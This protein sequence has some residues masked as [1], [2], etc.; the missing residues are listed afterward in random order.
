MVI[1]ASM[2]LIFHNLFTQ[3]LPLWNHY[4]GGVDCASELDRRGICERPGGLRSADAATQQSSFVTAY[5]VDR[6]RVNAEYEKVLDW[7]KQVKSERGELSYSQK[8]DF[9]HMP[10]VAVIVYKQEHVGAEPTWDIR[11]ALPKVQEI[12]YQG[13]DDAIG[14]YLSR[15]RHVRAFLPRS[16]WSFRLRCHP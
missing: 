5:T 7:C 12:I 10:G 9:L 13:A 1:F 16:S 4:P 15:G 2:Q 3:E 14:S 6:G 11:V 8:R